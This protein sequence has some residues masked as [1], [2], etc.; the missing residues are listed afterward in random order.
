MIR[1]S[2]PPVIFY[3]KDR[4]QNFSKFVDI[5]MKIEGKT[6]KAF[7]PDEIQSANRKGDNQ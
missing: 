1:I 5:D 4:E 3:P 6:H 7:N 2:C